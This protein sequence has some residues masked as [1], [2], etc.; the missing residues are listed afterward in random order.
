MNVLGI[1]PGR[2]GS[3]VIVNSTERELLNPKLKSAAIAH[4]LDFDG[5]GLKEIF[6]FIFK[7]PATLNAIYLENPPYMTNGKFQMAS[8]SGKLQENYGLCLG[9]AY[10]YGEVNNIKITPLVPQVWQKPYHMPSGMEYAERKDFLR[11]V[12]CSAFA[13][14]STQTKENQYAYADA[15]LIALYGCFDILNKR[16]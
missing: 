4:K 12:A 9:A 3:A 5:R 15:A 11:R 2:R 10:A 16:T 7:P 8:W 1:D 6:D 13:R 14:F